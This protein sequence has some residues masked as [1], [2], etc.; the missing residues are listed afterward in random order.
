MIINFSVSN[1]GS[2]RELQTLSFE[3]EKSDNLENYYVINES[4]YRLL[5]LA[6]IYGA[7]ASGKTSILRAL[8]F[9]RDLV[10]EPESKK[11]NTLKFEPFLFDDVSKNSLTTLTLEFLQAGKKYLYEIELTKKYI[12][13]ELLY[14]YDTRKS[15]VYKRETNI[16][17]QFTQIS[18]GSKF[19]VDKS[20][21]KTLE[22]NTLWNNT[23]LGGFLKT[24]INLKVLNT[25]SDWFFDYLKPI[26]LSKTDLEGYITH[27]INSNDINKA[28]VIN[29]LRKADFNISDL[30]INE[31]KNHVDERMLKVFE[32][33]DIPE[34]KIETM[35][36]SSMIKLDFE[37]TIDDRKYSLPFNNE[38]EGT[39]RYYAFAGLLVML[40]QKG[41][42][43]PID[44]L[45]SS[46]HPDLYTHFLLTF[47]INS[48]KSQIIA[49]THNRE[50]LNNRDIFRDDAI[51]FTNKCSGGSTSLYSLADIDSTV[52]RDTSNIFNAYK[53]GKLG[54]VP[55]LGDYYVELSNNEKE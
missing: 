5:K 37:H 22:A 2:I 55:N 16:E 31:E 50:I 9:I 3:A 27:K 15:L 18:F 51:W 19:T 45:E 32:A 36:E 46:L 1:F 26:V 43:I 35:K 52:V 24:N 12:T 23:V 54:G 47:L 34:D 8:D 21:R 14:V 39:Q 41:I 38:S 4:G 28:D 25:V 49:T 7:N 48:K 6:L 13:K 20:F 30:S 33:L 11:N 40:L 29:I 53:I 44:E 17:K 10:V 42:A